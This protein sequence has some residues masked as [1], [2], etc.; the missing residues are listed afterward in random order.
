MFASVVLARFFAFGFSLETVVIA[1]TAAVP[2]T[3][4]ASVV[5]VEVVLDAEVAAGTLI[6]GKA[7]RLLRWLANI[8]TTSKFVIQSLGN[9]VRTTAV[10][11]LDACATLEVGSLSNRLAILTALEFCL[12]TMASLVV[13]SYG[14]GET[15]GTAT[16]LHCLARTTFEFGSLS[17][18]DLVGTATELRGLTLATLLL[19]SM[20]RR[21]LVGTAAVGRVGT[22]TTLTIWSSGGKNI[23]WA[24]SKFRANTTTLSLGSMSGCLVVWAASEGFRSAGSTALSIGSCSRRPTIRTAAKL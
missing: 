9:T 23:V 4:T 17:N 18:G 5:G 2:E 16:K 8:L 7:A 20:S 24:A 22:L 3:S 13:W 6:L 19:W 11:A 1:L 15:I 14:E 12:C 21:F 10:L